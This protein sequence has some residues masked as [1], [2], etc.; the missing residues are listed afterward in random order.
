MTETL[1]S[2][3]LNL[4]PEWIRFLIKGFISVFSS[5]STLEVDTYL[6]HHVECV[7]TPTFLGRIRTSHTILVTI[8]GRRLFTRDKF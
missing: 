2:P 1:A 5:T 7:G 8:I 4:L 3:L 6:L